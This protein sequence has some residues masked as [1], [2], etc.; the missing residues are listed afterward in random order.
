MSTVKK[1]IIVSML[2]VLIGIF[3]SPVALG[4]SM[5]F[6]L[7]SELGGPPVLGFSMAPWAFGTQS[8]VTRLPLYFGAHGFGFPISLGSYRIG[9]IP[10]CG[11]MY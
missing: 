9:F 6:I 2:V 8:C 3:T 11:P 4:Q 7:G 1:I 10:S 5:P